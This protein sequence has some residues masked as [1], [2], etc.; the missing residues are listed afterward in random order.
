MA[1]LRSDDLIMA[2]REALCVLDKSNPTISGGLWSGY[3]QRLLKL[4]NDPSCDILE[5]E[6]QF[7]RDNGSFLR[8]S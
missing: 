2:S 3:R 5:I 7:L 6:P 1:D 8:A 4:I